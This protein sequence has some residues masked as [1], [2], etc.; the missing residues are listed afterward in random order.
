[1][2]KENETRQAILEVVARIACYATEPSLVDDVWAALLQAGRSEQFLM[3]QRSRAGQLSGYRIC[4]VVKMMARY[5]LYDMQECNNASDACSFRR[6]CQLLFPD[7]NIERYR[8][9]CTVYT[10]FE[11]ELIIRSFTHS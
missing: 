7:E 2:K 11:D 9:N 6:L 3:S 4:A 5:G 10:Y 1:M 8:R